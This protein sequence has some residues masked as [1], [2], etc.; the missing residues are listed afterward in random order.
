MWG[1]PQALFYAGAIVGSVMLFVMSFGNLSAKGDMGKM[2]M[3][4]TVIAAFSSI[5]LVQASSLSWAALLGL[6]IG[7]VGSWMA[8]R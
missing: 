3:K 8:M 1:W 4:V 6:L 2:G 5:F 7:L